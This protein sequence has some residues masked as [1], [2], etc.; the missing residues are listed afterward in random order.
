VNA[1]S[2]PDAASRRTIAAP[3]PRLPPVTKAALP[4]NSVIALS[5]IYRKVQIQLGTLQ[6]EVKDFIGLSA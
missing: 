1:T 5:N 4:V 3:M 6:E 2:A